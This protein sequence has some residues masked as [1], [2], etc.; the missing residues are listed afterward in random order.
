MCA[1]TLFIF[2]LSV[3]IMQYVGFYLKRFLKKRCRVDNSS[4]YNIISAHSFVD[5]EKI[6]FVRNSACSNKATL[7]GFSIKNKRFYNL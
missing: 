5:Y 6:I 2:L 7:K 3:L 1:S 4:L